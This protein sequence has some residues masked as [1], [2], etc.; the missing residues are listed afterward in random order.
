MWIAVR[1]HGGRQE[2]RNM[3]IAHSAPIYVVVDGEPTW[4]RDKA[5]EIVADLRKQLNAMLT[6]PVQ[7]FSTNPWETRILET[8]QWPL[9]RPLLKPYVAR[10]D[11]AYAKLLEAMAKFPGAAP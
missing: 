1:A 7:Q 11:A 9:Q 4:N 5:P 6:E 10:A 8:E 3:T 2:P